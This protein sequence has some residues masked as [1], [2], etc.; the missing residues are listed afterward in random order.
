MRELKAGGMA[1]VI[2]SGNMDEVGRVV[3]LVCAIKSGE[4]YKFPDG[5]KY[6]LVTTTPEFVWVVEGDVSV[7]THAKKSSGGMSIFRAK[8][9]MPIEGGDFSD[10]IHSEKENSHA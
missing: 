5:E 6:A 3:T 8:S 10:E 2:S 4:F 1:V 7:Y 9:L